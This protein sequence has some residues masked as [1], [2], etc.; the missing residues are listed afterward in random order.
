[1]SWASHPEVNRRFSSSSCLSRRS[2]L[3][4]ILHTSPS[5]QSLLLPLFNNSVVSALFPTPDGNGLRHEHR[6][7]RG[8]LCGGGTELELALIELIDDL[9]HG[10][11]IQIG[12]SSQRSLSLC[13]GRDWRNCG[14]RCDENRLSRPRRVGSRQEARQ[15]HKS[16]R[17]IEPSAEGSAHVAVDPR[18]IGFIDGRS[19]SFHRGIRLFKFGMKFHFSCLSFCAN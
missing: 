5:W 9:A 10:S 12:R 13:G 16:H 7:L 8:S 19:G 17:K 4:P 18:V 1:M 2:L 3:T 14:R 6:A 11:L 15:D